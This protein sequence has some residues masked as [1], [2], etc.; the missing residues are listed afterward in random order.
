MRAFAFVFAIVFLIPGSSALLAQE[1]LDLHDRSGAV[2]G[3]YSLEDLQAF[4]QTS[5]LTANDFVDGR[6]TFTGP[7]LQD[8]MADA[9]LDPDGMVLLTAADDYQVEV[10]A[11]EFT[12]YGAI[13][14]LTQDGQM[15]SRRDK[16]PI[17]VIYPMSD[18][19]E[20]QDPVYN[21]RLIWQ[22]VRIDEK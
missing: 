21:G 15:L 10:D 11:Q 2:A 16:G 7:L 13:L 8:V 18:F 19:K 22:L 9:G 14:A 1:V 12:R 3:A 5:I 17:W 20:L 6:V 4:E